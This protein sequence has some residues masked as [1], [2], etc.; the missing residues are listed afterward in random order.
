MLVGLTGDVVQMTQQERRPHRWWPP[1]VA[2]LEKADHWR[3]DY[4]ECHHPCK[5]LS[6][7]C[8]HMH[9]GRQGKESRQKTKDQGLKCLIWLPSGGPYQN[10]R[11]LRTA[12]SWQ[13]L[14]HMAWVWVGIARPSVIKSYRQHQQSQGQTRPTK[15][16][17][18]IG[19]DCLPLC[20]CCNPH[21][22][23]HLE[24]FLLWS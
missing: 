9:W 8:A 10:T 24:V 7:L 15:P 18:P 22:D 13:G 23:L 11:P 5:W 6:T 14:T 21:T 1:V 3:E 12:P 2:T 17:H 4:D 16:H 19:H 20:P